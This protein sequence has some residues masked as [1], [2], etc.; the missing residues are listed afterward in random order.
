MNVKIKETEKYKW[1]YQEEYD[2]WFKNRDSINNASIYH[3]V[4]EILNN[5]LCNQYNYFNH[6][7]HLSI[8]MNNNG[9]Y[10]SNRRNTNKNVFVTSGVVFSNNH[11]RVVAQN[12]HNY[13][14]I[15]LQVIDKE[16]NNIKFLVKE[17]EIKSGIIKELKTT[18]N[19]NGF[20]SRK[21]IIVLDTLSD[22][23][24]TFEIDDNISFDKVQE[25]YCKEHFEETLL[26]LKEAVNSTKFEELGAISE[27]LTL[28][29]ESNENN[30][31]LD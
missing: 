7:K 31:E 15:V 29:E 30:N 24:E 6:S 5:E 1:I 14:L 16:T 21:D 11:Y 25:E 19:S 27:Q 20:N 13:D 26:L 28:V 23:I 3:F 8:F 22:F 4:A 18:I 12:L 10:N 17:S 2:N 9:I